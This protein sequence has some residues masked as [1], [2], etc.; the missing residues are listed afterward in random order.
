LW[1]HTDAAFGLFAGLLD[2]YK[3][4]LNGIECSDSI[5]VDCHKWL[6]TPYD[7]AVAYVK[8]K[9]Y[10]VAV[11]KNIAPYLNEPGVETPW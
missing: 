11:F 2:D 5:T 3:S 10:Q 6:N 1:I 4:K 7:G 9:K 8:E